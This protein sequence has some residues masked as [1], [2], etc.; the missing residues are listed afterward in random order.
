MKF[1]L[2][3]GGLYLLLTWMGY[4]FVPHSELIW[5][6]FL[7]TCIVLL[8]VNGIIYRKEKTKPSIVSAALLPLVALIFIFLTE[9][10]SDATTKI[11]IIL[12]GLILTSSIILFFVG[13]KG[14][15]VK[16]V[17]GI[18]YF[19]M[20]QTM[21][22]ALF[23]LVFGF[24]SN[25]VVQSELSPNAVY[26]AEIIAGNHGA[27]GGNTQ[28]QVAYPNSNINLLVGELRRNPQQ[29]YF[30]RW[31]EFNGMTLRWET[32]ERLYVYFGTDTMIF[33]RVGIHWERRN[34]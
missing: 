3:S 24:G 5:G 8:T 13:T 32:D 26:S 27:L 31:G 33:E 30:G 15:V 6:V 28:V 20:L 11:N 10:V 23:M 12:I 16:A 22:L 1:L 4:T 9:P 29:V 14:I 17:L 34:R 21:S 7:I 18:L 19:V 2:T 25:E